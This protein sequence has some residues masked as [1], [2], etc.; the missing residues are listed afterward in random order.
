[1]NEPPNWPAVLIYFE[2][3]EDNDPNSKDW[4][5]AVLATKNGSTWTDLTGKAGQATI[6][7]TPDD[8]GIIQ[9][10]N[11]GQYQA[12]VTIFSNV[13]NVGEDL[14]FEYSFMSTDDLRAPAVGAGVAILQANPD[15]I[16]LL[17]GTDEELFGTP[18]AE[19]YFTPDSGEKRAE[20]VE[21]AAAS[22]NKNFSGTFVLNVGDTG[23]GRMKWKLADKAGNYVS[24]RKNF[25]AGFLASGG[26]TIGDG[27]AS[28]RVPSGTLGKSTLFLI[29]PRGGYEESTVAATASLPD[30][31]SRA[32]ETVGPAYDY[33][34]SWARLVKPAEI[35]LSYDGL[36]VNREDYLSVYRWNGSGWEDLG[37]T[38]DKRGRRVVATADRLG[39]FV[40]GYGEKKGSTPPS[41]KPMAFGLYQNYPNP[42]R[43]GT[44]ITY[45]L[46]AASE[47]TLT[48]YDLSGRRIATIVNAAR[49]AGVYK[50]EYTLTDDAGRPL[51]A[52]VY[53]YRLAA[54]A[55]V[56]TKKMVV[57]R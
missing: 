16:E 33:A 50:E 46:P 39:T 15:Y 25:S 37:G 10:R 22:G 34:P 48:V 18:E 3:D 14:P 29:T 56:A 7:F 13:A 8:K 53:L 36:T 44:V 24:G 47:V 35:T 51:P 26:G 19:V 17:I 31:E 38:I 4:G 5:G 11:P 23:T 45:A 41:G 12:I 49:E 2:G 55:D 52:G 32:V 57:A 21:M 40:L 27:K 43:N 1:M 9:I 20:L 42:A 30:G 28:L 54:G 6:M